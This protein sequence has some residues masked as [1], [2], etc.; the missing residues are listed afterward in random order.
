MS[1]AKSRVA[2]ESSPSPGSLLRCERVNRV[3]SQDA[4]RPPASTTRR[5]AA[6]TRLDTARVSRLAAPETRPIP[7]R[8]AL[9]DLLICLDAASED[10]LNPS[11]TFP[12]DAAMTELPPPCRASWI[13]NPLRYSSCCCSCSRMMPSASRTCPRW[14]TSPVILTKIPSIGKT[15][16]D[17]DWGSYRGGDGTS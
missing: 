4:D 16:F 8:T 9:P 15:T 3:L 2:Y 7:P 5:V 14:V 12:S 17:V 11:V 13:S 6:A 10:R 1:L